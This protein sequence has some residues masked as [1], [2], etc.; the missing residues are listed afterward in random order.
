MTTTP[1]DALPA[2][3]VDYSA[4]L[5]ALA[6]LL[7]ANS[8]LEHF[9][10]RAWMAGDG[11]LGNS[12]FFLLAGYG[13][14]RSDL[15][16]KRTFRAWMWRRLVR[17][18]PTVLLVVAVLALGVDGGWRVWSW[19]DYL[20]ELV[21]PTEFTFVQLI[22]PFYV[23]FFA[24][25]RARS[26]SVFTWGMILAGALYFA[27]YIPDAMRTASND[28]LHLSSRPYFAHAFAYFQV[29]L[30]GAWLGATRDERVASWTRWLAL[31]AASVAYLVVKLAM[32]QGH[33]AREY[34][35]LHALTFA[36]CLLAFECFRDRAIIERLRAAP[37][38]WRATT[39]V[40]GLTLEIYVV[41]SF[42]AEYAWLYSIRFP[43]NIVVFWAMTLPSAWLTWRVVSVIQA[44]LRGDREGA[45]PAARSAPDAALGASAAQ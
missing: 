11:L 18:Y 35:L 44:R 43:L 17:L 38:L 10:P 2:E 16:R 24:L 9:Y 8:H 4:L 21:W 32:V 13:L 36:W 1:R 19:R 33:F 39:F 12:L 25:L 40:G 14:V 27:V 31:A 26:R 7:V 34:V 45:F 3:R 29:M 42:F 37:R 22:V 23:V 15:V 41:H 5:K 28:T 6:A 20:R 30:V